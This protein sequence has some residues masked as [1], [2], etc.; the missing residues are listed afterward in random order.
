MHWLRFAIFLL[1]LSFLQASS[2][3]DFIALT[4]FNIKPDFLLSLL[5]FFAVFSE[6]Y[7]AIITSFAIGL[8][9]D[10]I[11]TPIGPYI[12]SFGIL[13]S[14]LSTLRRIIT[15]RQTLYIM[16]A[17]FAVGMTAIPLAALLAYF[18]GDAF[19]TIG[20]IF[21]TAVY[22]AFITPYI[23]AILTAASNWMGMK[24]YR[25]TRAS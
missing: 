4:K 17:V 16:L 12:V 25:I 3:V 24:R 10:I 20:A 21:G 15:I 13:G 18:K 9:A 7:E 6:G 2:A 1:L 5:V 8:A 14:L 19:P 11:K 22:S 23:F